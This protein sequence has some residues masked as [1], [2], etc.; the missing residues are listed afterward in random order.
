VPSVFE[1]GTSSQQKFINFE[2]VETFQNWYGNTI[3]FLCIPSLTRLGKMMPA[4][5][6]NEV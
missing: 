5:C 4:S 1:T 6:K 2:E 3:A